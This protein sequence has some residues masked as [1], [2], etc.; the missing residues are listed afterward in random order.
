MPS[1][2]HGG[3]RGPVTQ[4]NLDQK[5]KTDWLKEWITDRKLCWTV[6]LFSGKQRWEMATYNAGINEH[7]QLVIEDREFEMEVYLYAK[8]GVDWHYLFI[9]YWD[10]EDQDWYEF[11]PSVEWRSYLEAQEAAKV[12]AGRPKPEGKLPNPI[13]P[14]KIKDSPQ[15]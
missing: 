1:R 10:E 4:E 5:A 7:G 11:K 15:A 12:Q 14:R 13:T 6:G 2:M 8:A 3:M 9:T